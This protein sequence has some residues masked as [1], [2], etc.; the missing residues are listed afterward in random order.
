MNQEYN[1]ENLK[2]SN[3]NG[4]FDLLLKLVKDKQMDIFSIDLV[5][6]ANEYIKLIEILKDKEDMDTASEYLVMSATLLQLKARMILEIP[7]EKEEVEAEKKDILKKL[8]EYQQYKAVADQLKERFYERR[9]LHDKP[10]S[11]YDKFQPEIDETK[12][13]GKSDAVKLIMQL[14]KMFER[15]RANHLRHTTIDT[16][17][18]SP[19]ERRL[20]VIEILKKN[21]NPTFEDIFTVPTINHF[22]ITMLTILDM[23][24]KQELIIK[25]DEQFDEITFEKGIINE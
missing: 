3:F 17:N 6:L 9:K 25:Q 20:E 10:V 19:A 21:S 15:I 23:S 16:I 11:D 18:L 14:R 13:D 4:P 22:A 24:R 8:A 2:L 1:E 5:E 7:S 12:L